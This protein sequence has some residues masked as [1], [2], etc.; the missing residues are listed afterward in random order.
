MLAE[1]KKKTNIEFTISIMLHAIATLFLVKQLVDSTVVLG[2]VELKYEGGA[3]TA[4]VV[5][6]KDAAGNYHL[7]VATW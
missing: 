6:S 2:P 3:Q 4:R 5:A 7:S 1:T